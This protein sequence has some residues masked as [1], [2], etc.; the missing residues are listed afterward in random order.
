MFRLSRYYSIASLIGIG[1]VIIALSFFFRHLALQTL[2][3]HQTRANIDLTNSFANSIW[4]EFSG[5]VDLSMSFT[6]VDELK[7][8]P[9]LARL[10]AVTRGQM[11]GTNVV[12]IKIYNLNGL[13]VFSTD[14]NQ[15]GK[16]KSKDTGYLQARS[17]EV[18]SA[19]TFRNEF[20][21][22]EQVIM[23]R[24][25]IATYTPI[26]EQANGPV[27]AVFE[28]YSDVTPLVEDME[29]TQ[30]KIIAG[31]FSSLAFLYLFLF[32]IVKRA[33][34]IITRQ[35]QQRKENEDNIRH[36][37]YHDSLTGL[38]NRDNFLERMDEAISRAKRHNKNGALMF[39]DLD[40]FKLIND[41]LGH[42][43][44]DQLLRITA[45]RIQ[46]CMRE[47]DMAFRM[48]GD[49]F[50]V[51]MEDLDKG[52]GAAVPARRVLQEMATPVALN[53]H[54]VIVNISIGITTFPKADID[55]EGLVKEADSAMYRAKQTGHNQY[56]FFSPE[57][58]MVACERL[59]METDLQRA[60][61]NDEFVLYYQPKVDAESR[62][63]MS[64][65]AL[66]RWQH[67]EKG[68]TPPNDFIP[69]LEDTGLI[70]IVGEW[71]I[72]TACQ[73]AQYWIASGYQPL[74][75]SVNISGKQFRNKA[76]IPSV[77]EALQASGLDAKY[78]ELELTESMFVED[79]EYAI[80][81]MHE[82]KELGVFLSIDD[83]GSGYSSLS[84]LKQF[85]VD[86]LKIDRSF[87]KDLAIN[88]K[89]VAITTAIAALAHSLNLGLIAEGVEDE[90]Q[91]ELLRE[92]GCHELQ[93]FLFSKPVPGDELEKKLLKL[94]VKATG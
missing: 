65:E 48:S 46:K 68:L 47:T 17:G 58:N 73:Q 43:A 83:F 9:E 16:V 13:T 26:R 30:N 92:K 74:R 25:L 72:F 6:S 10:H 78:L 50:V 60:I 89:D 5:F 81:V 38:P 8:R 87:I 94:Q 24:N 22:F 31:V 3:K 82:L 34:S 51:I 1:I 41:S 91:V 40:R 59:T 61:K 33:D 19:I 28:V 79:T 85:P 54:E 36:Q 45:S 57:M 14:P 76:L 35:E 27:T 49:E 42:D 52:E 18:A 53:G 55:V 29:S 64:V 77:R 70:N 88:D 44:G 11:K 71:V 86:Y 62:E 67:P 21:A 23:D 12:K 63:I 39:L 7:Q 15:I 75:M 20:Y 90:Q 69:L 32:V 80:S 84:Y 4:G 37:A 2:M 56:E 93:G 66:I